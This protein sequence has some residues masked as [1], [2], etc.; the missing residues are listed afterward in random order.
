[1][2]DRGH[3]LHYL[4][5][6]GQG[7]LLELAADPPAQLLAVHPGVEPEHPDVAA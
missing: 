5:P 4:D 1:M 2:R 7:R 3:T 6:V